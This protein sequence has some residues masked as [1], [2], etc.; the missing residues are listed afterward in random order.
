M[1]NKI[2]R[3]LGVNDKWKC[4][5]L[6][7]VIYFWNYYLLIKME[8]PCS[9]E[10]YYLENQCHT[11]FS[12]SSSFKYVLTFRY[13]NYLLRCVKL[14]WSLFILEVKLGTFGRIFSEFF[15]LNVYGWVK[16]IQNICWRSRTTL[17]SYLTQI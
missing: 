17:L 16:E 1:K 4:I 15:L 8:K 10:N 9:H 12:M 14:F 6:L 3:D 13:L 7:Y 5:L 11:L 2:V